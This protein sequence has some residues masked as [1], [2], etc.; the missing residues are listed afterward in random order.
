MS[1]VSLNTSQAFLLSRQRAE[2]DATR[3]DF[4]FWHEVFDQAHGSAADGASHGQGDAGGMLHSGQPAVRSTAS[5]RPD[6]ATAGHAGQAASPSGQGGIGQP[7]VVPAWQTVR[8]PSLQVPGLVGVVTSPTPAGAGNAAAAAVSEAS[9]AEAVS[10]PQQA[11]SSAAPDATEPESAIRAHVMVSAEGELKVA[12]RAHRGL[13]VSQA[14]AAV[15]Q[16]VNQA[17]ESGEQVEQVVLNGERIYQRVS[18]RQT[19]A[20]TSSTFELKC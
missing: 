6:S 12:L 13:S 14:L 3:P 16:A 4:Q 5:A 2:Q 15:A 17:G 8:S 9:L 19:G 1:H 7:Q 20:K 11:A 18:E 10:W